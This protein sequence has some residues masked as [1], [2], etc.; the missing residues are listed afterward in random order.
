MATAMRQPTLET[1]GLGSVLALLEE[2]H[3]L[4]HR[5][6]G[7]RILIRKGKDRL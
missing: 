4:Q 3:G 7:G 5:T 6:E 2:F 1:L